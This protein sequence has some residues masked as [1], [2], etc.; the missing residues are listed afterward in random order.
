MA[1]NCTRRMGD[2]CREHRGYT[3]SV[4]GTEGLLRSETMP[5]EGNDRCAARIC[6]E[7]QPK[8][9]CHDGYLHYAC[10][11]H[12]ATDEDLRICDIC[13]ADA[14]PRIPEPDGLDDNRPHPAFLE[15]F[16][17]PAA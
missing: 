4:C 14:E 16:N 12:L 7:C 8:Q 2:E 5:C 13:R 9:G 11:A 3:C 6:E 15:V 1:C 17:E 10:P